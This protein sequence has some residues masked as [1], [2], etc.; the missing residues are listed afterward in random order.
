[1]LESQSAVGTRESGER[2]REDWRRAGR[3][4]APRARGQPASPHVPRAS[5]RSPRRSGSALGSRYTLCPARLPCS[6]PRFAPGFATSLAG[7]TCACTDYGVTGVGIGGC[8]AVEKNP[9]SCS[10]FAALHIR[11]LKKNTYTLAHTVTRDTLRGHTVVGGQLP[12]S[13]LGPRVV[14]TH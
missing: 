6:W 14:G 10:H 5:V 13:D 1:M 2:T 7:G 4:G 3:A 11:S 9:L 8:A 12:A